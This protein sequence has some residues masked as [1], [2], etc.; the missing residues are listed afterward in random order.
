MVSDEAFDANASF[1]P[2]LL[3][4][5]L[6]FAGVCHWRQ[7]WNA[8]RFRRGSGRDHILSEWLPCRVACLLA[9]AHIMRLLHETLKFPATVLTFRRYYVGLEGPGVAQGIRPCVTFGYT[10]YSCRI[11]PCSRIPTGTPRWD[12]ERL[13]AH[14]PASSKRNTRVAN[15]PT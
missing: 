9:I 14:P 1:S 12:M 3:P 4:F 5:L 15:R 10:N 11:R 7:L 6:E 13:P 8:N 2:H